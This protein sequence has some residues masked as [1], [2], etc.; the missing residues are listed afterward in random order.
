MTKRVVAYSF[1]YVCTLI[2]AVSVAYSQDVQVIVN[3]KNDVQSFSKHDLKQIFLAKKR[4]FSSGRPIY[5]VTN[6]E[7]E[8]LLSAFTSLIGF[9]VS[10]FSRVWIKISLSG[11]APPPEEAEDDAEMIELVSKEVGAIGFVKKGNVS[12]KVKVVEI[13]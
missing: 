6:T 3:K 5:L 9:N 7:D 11:E 4:I 10:K 13:K 8:D 2:V 1:L 12:D